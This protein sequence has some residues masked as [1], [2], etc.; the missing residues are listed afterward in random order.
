MIGE[1]GKIFPIRRP[2]V[3]SFDCQV[4][5]PAGHPP[6]ATAVFRPRLGPVKVVGADMGQRVAELVIAG[7]GVGLKLGEASHAAALT[8]RAT[9]TQCGLSQSRSRCRFVLPMDSAGPVKA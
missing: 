2:G 8:F 5:G 3:E 6:A 1:K 4:Y 7:F 9:R